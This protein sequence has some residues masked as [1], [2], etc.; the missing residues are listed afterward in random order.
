MALEKKIIGLPVEK[1]VNEKVSDRVLPIGQLTDAENVC[2]DKL[3]EAKK[4]S[5]FWST[6][7]SVPQISDGATTISKGKAVASF[8]DEIVCF[9]GRYAYTRTS[10]AT[11]PWVNKGTVVGC[12]LERNR[13]AADSNLIQTAA[14]ITQNGDFEFHVWSEIDPTETTSRVID[15]TG[16]VQNG[17]SIATAVTFTGSG[18]NDLSAVGGTYSGSSNNTRF[19]IIVTSGTASPDTITWDRDTGSGY[20]GG[21][22]PI[23]ITAGAMTLESGV[24]VTFDSTEGHTK[25]DKWEFTVGYSRAK[26]T[27]ATDHNLSPGGRVTA[28]F[29]HADF[30]DG[31]YQVNSVDSTSSYTVSYNTPVANVSSA[32]DSTVVSGHSWRTYCKV[33]D[34]KTK[35]EIIGKKLINLFVTHN[36][37]HNVPR[38]Q[39][40]SVDSFVYV[41]VHVGSGRV[42]HIL[43][44][45]ASGLT[46]DLMPSVLTPGSGETFLVDETYPHFLV[47]PTNYIEGASD[48]GFVLLRR[49]DGTSSQKLR[50]STWTP[51]VNGALTELG[52]PGVVKITDAVHFHTPNLSTTARNY[53][54]EEYSVNPREIE[55]AGGLMLSVVRPHG[56]DNDLYVVVGYTKSIDATAAAGFT[57]VGSDDEP[58]GVYFNV[59]DSDLDIQGGSNLATLNGSTTAFV[60]ETRTIDNCGYVLI[61]G[62]AGV[63]ARQSTDNKIRVFS[64]L[65][66]NTK[67]P[68]TRSQKHLVASHDVMSNGSTGISDNNIDLHW[69][70]I[71]GD[72]FYNNS[73]IYFPVGYASR[74]NPTDAGA[75]PT[76]VGNT[77]LN[78]FNTAVEVMV[79]QHG[80]VVAKG[81]NSTGPWTQDMNFRYMSHFVKAEMNRINFMHALP[82][83]IHVSSPLVDATNVYRFGTSYYNG[84]LVAKNG[85]EVTAVNAAVS[86]FNMDPENY[87]P[88]VEANGSLL[89]AGGILWQ[90]SGDYFKEQ[91]FFW[92]PEI[93][94]V[95]H[96]AGSSGYRV[97]DGKHY[98]KA[99]YE[100]V[101]S[102]GK[103]Q[104]SNPS[105]AVATTV[106]GGGKEVTV[107]VYTLQLTY[108]HDV[109]DTI[110]P[111]GAAATFW[112]G[113]STARIILYRTK[114]DGSRYFRCAEAEMLTTD[115]HQ[116][117][118]DTLPDSKLVDN[119]ELYT[120]GGKLG[121]FCP[122]SQYDI[123][124]WKDRVF[125]ATT[126]NTL[127]YSKRFSENRETAFNDDPAGFIRSVDNRSE[128]IRALCPNLDHLLILGEKNGYYMS[129]EGPNDAAAGV[130]FSPLRVFAPGQGAVEGT[131]RAETPLGVFFQ[132]A[133]GLM[134][135]GR[136]M[137][138]TY[139][140]ARIE[141]QLGTARILSADVFEREGEV[142]FPLNDSKKI[143]VYNYLF[144]QW[145]HWL[146]HSDTGNNAGTTQV[147]NATGTPEHYRLNDIGVLYHQ[148]ETETYHDK[149]STTEKPY[150]M[151]LTSGW[152]NIGQLQQVGRI[153]KLLLLGNFNAHS[154]PKVTIY[155]DYNDSSGTTLT[156]SSV[157]G[158]SKYQLELKMPKQK[159]RAF[160]FTIT[161]V[162]SNP[163]LDGGIMKIQGIAMLVGLKRAGSSFKLPTANLIDT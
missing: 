130:D 50:L 108:K 86:E 120:E 90:Y 125:L 52:T 92:W 63:G 134:L 25:D 138:V 72:C 14:Q 158:T 148:D 103:I 26:L 121:H 5:G 137:Q 31:T 58:G 93:H 39:I 161:E 32:G 41:F 4:R 54:T 100:W 110:L 162:L 67:A 87:L 159:V 146:L 118:V 15:F 135:C 36:S 114:V 97:D 8:G 139:A 143:L 53:S 151:T 163:S 73:D 17:G 119:P 45:T 56:Q 105:I 101:D 104:R 18:T 3:G 29:D 150:Y 20:G 155:T 57:D 115:C 7:N 11:E 44:K 95:T 51:D 141:D 49:L 16:L 69:C 65:I 1:G 2:F 112:G 147:K 84:T 113:R 111:G 123:A 46:A 96:A 66:K 83:V 33:L 80:E 129:G 10:T 64:T 23:N 12:T 149:I 122:P 28:A 132:T 77:A 59:Y 127:L 21:A 74:P 102:Q 124:V 81:S 68:A 140:G 47:A 98:Y 157:P 76:E 43:M 60:D 35:A 30:T 82:R 62:C 22:G 78:Q 156:T 131:C 40:V 24:T 160:K 27:G 89:L 109:T 126:E 144:D 116:E 61:N 91:N 152:I 42:K 85:G 9:D 142:R 48:N 70:T 136:D 153:Y 19:R 55:L 133:Q 106:A 154:L 88:S 94:S 71:T 34:K 6:S 145:S 75:S 128:K 117:I 13:V 37:I 38:A 107:K 79:N 99:I